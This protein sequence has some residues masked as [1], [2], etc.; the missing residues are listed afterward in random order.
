VSGGVVSLPQAEA[1]SP[2]DKSASARHIDSLPF[3]GL[4]DLACGVFEIIRGDDV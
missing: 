3:D 1:L 4:H 2:N